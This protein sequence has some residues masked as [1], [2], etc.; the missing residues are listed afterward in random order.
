MNDTSLERRQDSLTQALLGRFDVPAYIRRA[1]GVEDA[2]ERLLLHCRQQRR[3]LAADLRTHLADLAA[4]VGG[5]TGFACF[6]EPTGGLLNVLWDELEP[7]DKPP[8]RVPAS[9]VRRQRL[10]EDLI[11]EVY[12]VN[13]R[14]W[15]SLPEVDLAPLNA[16]REGYN[17]YYVLEKECALRSAQLAMQGFRPLEPLTTAGLMRLLPPLPVPDP[18]P[19][20]R[21]PQQA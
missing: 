4:V 19:S 13:L 17:R 3:R 18:T 7:R 2:L 11:A 20:R 14:F 6:G 8:A 21:K 10:L 9:P 16:L 1:R 15:D 12:R 5:R